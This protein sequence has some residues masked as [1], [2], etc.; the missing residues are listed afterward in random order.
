MPAGRSIGGCSSIAGGSTADKDVLVETQC[1]R[2]RRGAVVDGIYGAAGRRQVGAVG[3]PQ[4]DAMQG[5]Y[6]RER[7][8]VG[9]SA[10]SRILK[11]PRVSVCRCGARALQVERRAHT[12]EAVGRLSKFCK[13]C[14]C[15]SAKRGREGDPRRPGIT[16]PT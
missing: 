6:G 2:K 7:S 15:A 5:C 16:S 3:Q 4:D 9:R 10:R 8:P 14:A 12:A 11:S 13:G 1:E